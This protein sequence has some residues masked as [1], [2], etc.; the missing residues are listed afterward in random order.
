MKYSL[1]LTLFTAALAAPGNA[2]SHHDHRLHKRAGPLLHDDV[3]ALYQAAAEASPSAEPTATTL[4]TGPYADGVTHGGN[5]KLAQEASESQVPASASRPIAI[6]S[7]HYQGVPTWG[8]ATTVAVATIL[9]ASLSAF[10]IYKRRTRATKTITTEQEDALS[11]YKAFWEAKRRSAVS[12]TSADANPAAVAADAVA[13]SMTIDPSL[14]R[15]VD[16]K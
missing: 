8:I 13:K 12:F 4:S 15:Y 2:H 3:L 6:N 14:P 9:L 16:V 5:V 7:H 10:I 11:N 1:I